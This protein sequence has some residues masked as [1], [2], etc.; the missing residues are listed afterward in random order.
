MKKLLLMFFVTLFIASAGTFAAD[1]PILLETPAK[2][3]TSKQV[4]L[5]QIE[6]VSEYKDVS[7]LALVDSPSK[8]LNKNV[9]IKA[10]FDKFSTIGLDYPP[11]KK[12]AKT[13]ISFLIKREN[14]TAYNIP[15]SELKLIIKRDYAEKEMLNVEQGDDMEIYGKVFSVALGDPWVSVDKVKILTVHND[16]ENSEVNK[17]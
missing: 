16:K 17:K 10:K 9:K 1:A 8:Y 5:P 11:V 2:V 12:D 7:A 6:Q 4:I 14:V 3:E 15:L 13:Y